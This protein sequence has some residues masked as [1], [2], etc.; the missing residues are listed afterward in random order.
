MGEVHIETPLYILGADNLAIEGDFH[1]LVAHAT[2]VY[3]IVAHQRTAG[4]GQ[5][6][7]VE[8]V[9]S[10]TVVVFD[11]TRQ[12]MLEEFEVHTH[13]PRLGGFPGQVLVAL[14]YHGYRVAA[15][16][17]VV[18]GSVHVGI[19]MTVVE[20]GAA[21]QVV[22]TL[23]TVAQLQLEH[24]NPLHVLHEVLLAHLPCQTCGTEVTPA[25]SGSKHRRSIATERGAGEVLLLPVVLYAAQEAL[26]HL[27]VGIGR[28]ALLGDA[29]SIAE[30]TNEGVVQVVVGTA[31]VLCLVVVLLVTGQHGQ[32]V[33]AQ[34]LAVGS[35]VLLVGAEDTV[36]VYL[37]LSVH[38]EGTTIAAVEFAVAVVDGSCAEAGGQAE[39]LDGSHHGSPLSVEE[40]TYALG[41]V[42]FVVTHGIAHYRGT[43][44][45]GLVG[46]VHLAAALGH[47]VALG[48]A[49]IEGIDGS[50]GVADVEQVAR[51]T[52]AVHVELRALALTVGEAHVGGELQP[53]LGLIVHIGAACVTG[54]FRVVH[55]TAVLQ[56]AHACIVA[57]A[58]AAAAGRHIVFLTEAVVE[59]L[60]VPVIGPVGVG[61][62]AVAQCGIGIE[63][64]V[65]ADE[66]LSF[67]H[68]VNLVAQT[69]VGS[70]EQVGIGKGISLGCAG[71]VV[72]L[73]V[74]HGP[75]VGFHVLAGIVN[76]IV[77]GNQTHVATPLG[78][79]SDECLLS[80][81]GLLGGDD[82]HT[83]GATG[84][85]DGTGGRI[86][87]HRDALD[88]LGVDAGD[89]A[90][91]R[92]TVHDIKRSVAGTQ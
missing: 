30:L 78:I 59:G 27:A 32:V 80:G 57:Q 91:I 14:L 48:I 21:R 6:L 16:S 58:V 90:I 10:G 37:H 3:G 76:H 2:H 19:G 41:A 86:L 46:V 56:V 38:S 20:S 84:T 5:V 75:V 26:V 52:P 35:Q 54:I 82:D 7:E 92:R 49:H 24:V 9:R 33:V 31:Q 73:G 70:I 89:V 61:T 87:Q 64:E 81:L 8:H 12:A 69:A 29:R 39:S 77:L 65:G 71:T 15:C 68:S 43:L 55:D 83:V 62:I 28:E 36:V 51:A 74:K 25:V 22:V 72:I 42:V 34:L 60:V 23:L 85:I 44:E 67:G 17:L 1:T 79:E 40:V 18:A 50:H 4:Q 63:L 11:G 53:V 88:V 45:V 66:V 13:V 47:D